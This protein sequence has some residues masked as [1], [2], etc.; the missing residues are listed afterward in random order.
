ITGIIAHPA[1]DR[2][3][4]LAKLERRVELLQEA[5][6]IYGETLAS[7]RQEAQQSLDVMQRA[8]DRLDGHNVSD[9]GRDGILVEPGD[10]V[11]AHELI[12]LAGN[13]G[14]RG[15]AT[16]SHTDEFVVRQGDSGFEMIRGLVQQLAQGM[17]LEGTLEYDQWKKNKDKLQGRL[18]QRIRLADSLAASGTNSQTGRPQSD[19]RPV[20]A[21]RYGTAYQTNIRPLLTP[22]QQ[23]EI[24]QQFSSSQNQSANSNNNRN[25]GQGR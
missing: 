3:E 16:H 23:A 10:H 7:I 17:P 15:T 21:R 12:G 13:T 20:Y 19:T 24:D 18:L 9:T 4:Y 6:R 1:A 22:Q 25:Q 8:L 2:D 14:P 5:G 11:D